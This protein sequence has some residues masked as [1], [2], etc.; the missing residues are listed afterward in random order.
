MLL[1]VIEH[2]S[3]AAAADKLLKSQSTVSYA[4]TRLQQ[5]LGVQIFRMQGRKAVLTEAGEL[6]LRRARGL[7][8]EARAL[9]QAALDLAHGWE[10]EIRIQ[11]DVI[12]PQDFL[13]R[14]LQRFAPES[15]HT[16]VELIE[17]SLSGTQDAI[18]HAQADI[19]LGGVLPTG[20][21]SESI[22]QIKFISV[23]HAQH[24]LVKLQRPLHE[25]DL[26]Q[27]RQIVVRDSG[28]RRRLDSGWLG[29]EQRW[30]VSHFYQSIN[31]LVA[32]LGYAFVPD[33]MVQSFMDRGELVELP[34]ASGSTRDVPL[35]MVFADSANAGPALQRFAEIVREEALA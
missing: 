9:E 21:L 3:F 23:A 15:R 11:V 5:H 8:S 33:H 10:P 7:V 18:V 29:A 6:V 12:F 2:G 30:T 13:T 26:K 16:R 20:F 34:V 27:H 31:L 24:P 22:G 4:M 35:H 17:G 25:V 14:V 19:A 32:G 28:P 1:A